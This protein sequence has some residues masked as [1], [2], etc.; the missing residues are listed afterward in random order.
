MNLNSNY[1]YIFYTYCKIMKMKINREVFKMN[2][3]KFDINNEVPMMTIKPISIPTPSNRGEELQV[4][5]SMPSE[6]KHL[7]IILFAHGFGSSMHAYEPL[8]DFWASHGF[9]VIQ[10]T[11]LDSRTIGLAQDDSRQPDIW[12]HRVEDLKSILDHLSYIEA[13]VPGLSGRLDKNRI[14]TIGHSFG[15]QTAGNLLGLQ[16]MDPDTKETTDLLDYRVKGG[17][18]L[19]TAGEGGDNLTQFAKDHMPFLNP[20]FQ[21]MTKPALVVVGDKDQSP[22]THL[23]PEW[24]EDPYYLS[25]GKKSLLKLYDAEHSLGGI[26]GYEA[27]ET[28]D[29]NP[30]RIDLLQHTTWAYLRHILDIEH[31]SLETAQN[32][33]KNDTNIA[34]VFSK[35]E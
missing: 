23:G 7:P 4:K 10:G 24:M 13:Q 35:E 14:A 34:D 25:P 19:A 2:E 28:T 26:A 18:L 3:F 11:H 22:L 6:G 27:K 1:K 29:E 5:V 16:V 31:D 8:T 21:Y 9:V 32:I 15:G 33:I 12:R 17:I 30:Q 20:T